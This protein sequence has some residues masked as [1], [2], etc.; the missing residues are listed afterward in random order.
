MTLI[1]NR[2]IFENLNAF[3]KIDV[4]YVEIRRVNRKYFIE[5]EASL[6]Q[7]ALNLSGLYEY[8]VEFEEMKMRK[9]I[10]WWV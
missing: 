1:R 4:K 10:L 7:L 8:W 3:R 9:P 6:L 5:V 2:M